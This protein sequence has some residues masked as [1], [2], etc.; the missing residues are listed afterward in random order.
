MIPDELIADIRAQT[1][2][3]A[4][5]G[6]YVR[7]TKRGANHLGLCPFHNEKTPSFNVHGGRGF[8]HCFGCQASGDA[9]GF[10]MRL[11]GLSF[12]EAARN[13]AERLGLELPES[14]SGED[15]RARAARE[16]K[17]GLYGLME[18]AA[19]FY[20]RQLL[21]H[22]QR[23][24]ALSALEQRGI[25]QETAKTF[26]LGFAP[27]AW[28]AL[29]RHLAQRDWS[30][31]DAEALGLIARR[32]DGDGHYDRFRNRLQFPVSDQSG[33]VVAFS[34]RALPDPR[35]EHAAAGRPP[36]KYVNS[37][38]GPLYTKGDLLFGLHQ[39]RVEIRRR[40][41]ALLCEGNFDLVALH[42]AG[43]GHAV[44]PLGTAFT[45]R[46]ARALSRFAGRVTLLFDGDAAGEKA[47]RAAHPLLQ[48]ALLPARVASLPKGEDPDSFL[49]KQGPESLSQLIDNAPGI[50]E[51]L[52]DMAADKGASSAA[53]RADAIEGLGPVLAAVSNPV[54][55]Q[56]YIERVAQRFGLSDL[57]AV[58]QQLRRGVI[59]SRRPVTPRDAPE[60]GLVE[61]PER[62]KLPKLQAELVGLLLDQ[63][64]LFASPEAKNLEEL[65]TSPELQG[66][67]RTAA[68]LFQEST[69]IDASALLSRI[70]S[71]HGAGWLRERLSVD[72]YQ[73]RAESE[74]VLRRGVTQL[75]VQN[76]ESKRRELAQQI[77]NA[78]RTGD[79]GLAIRLTRERDELALSAHRWRSQ[80]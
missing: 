72:T 9:I 25:T 31:A 3:V 59:A 5:I 55:I 28:D 71:A 58:R 1:D 17:Q 50:V 7:L 16:R 79:D 23:E 45:E 32:R 18:A 35:G 52:I 10:L 38:E 62:V 67:F 48:K 44:A 42:Q 34:G 56:L 11:E 20:E 63:P 78:R 43:F 53:D 36:P 70:G 49:R 47:A 39:A 61:R 4:L 65:L 46:Q 22:P 40:G 33:R 51:H 80:R 19:A 2:I 66:I 64:G 68:E 13:L 8:F 6:E 69:V 26:R 74:M 75:A 24:L 15:L 30:L 41:W 29:A 12:P 14:D 77:A 60:S 57:A 27:P 21:E 54:E 76:I 37:P 73:D